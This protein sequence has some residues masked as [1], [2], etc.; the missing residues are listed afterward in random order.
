MEKPYDPNLNLTESQRIQNRYYMLEDID[1]YLKEIVQHCDD[2]ADLIALGS[3][4]QIHSKNI[5]TA[6]MDKKD[7]RHIIKKF[8]DDVEKE[9]DRGSILKKYHGKY[10]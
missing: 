6:C 2:E 7:W 8:L 9:I 5:L 3:L 4:L 1:D 10:Y